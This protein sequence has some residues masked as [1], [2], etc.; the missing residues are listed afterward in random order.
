[1]KLITNMENFIQVIKFAFNEFVISGICCLILS[2]ISLFPNFKNS[3]VNKILRNTSFIFV[4]IGCLLMLI[5]HIYFFVLLR[6]N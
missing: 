4:V 6:Y 5:G 2:I 1:M 3:K